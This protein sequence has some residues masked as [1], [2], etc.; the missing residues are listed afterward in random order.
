MANEPAPGALKPGSSENLTIVNSAYIFTLLAAFFWGTSFVVIELGLKFIDPFWFAQLRFLVASMGSLVVVLLVRKRIDSKLLS[1]HWVWVMG[2][3]NVLGFI[4]Q[5]FGQTMTN[6]TRTALLVNLNLITVAV[7]S[8]I[9]FGE[10]FS[11]VK[12]L[13]VFSSIIGV[14]LLTTDGNLS[15]LTTGE[16]MGDMFALGAGFVWAFYIVTNKKVVIQ[17]KMD[18]ITLTACVM[19]TTTVI[20][21]PFTLVLGGV[22]PQKHTT[23]FE[24]VGYIIYLGIFCNVIPFILWTYG[25]KR[26]MPT[27]STLMLLFEVFI[28]SILAILIL[29]ESLTYIGILGG[30]II[31]AA[32]IMIGYDS[33][34]KT[35]KLLV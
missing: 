7:L 19:L 2:M 12:L 4:A 5:F 33:K 1:S 25:L 23:N 18:V 21:V 26:L 15:K 13:A 11:K 3:F 8:T 28:A 31:I 20:M 14:F 17:P 22:C 27:V 29:G 35:N 30:F 24:S 6:A 9:I 16:F 10:R 32:I 34:K